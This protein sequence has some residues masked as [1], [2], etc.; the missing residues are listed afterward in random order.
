MSKQHLF[1]SYYSFAINLR[2]HL[3]LDFLKP[4]SQTIHCTDVPE[5]N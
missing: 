2:D 1:I 4:N 3:Y 5:L